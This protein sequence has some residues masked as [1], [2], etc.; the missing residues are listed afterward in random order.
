MKF[1]ILVK[2]TNYGRVDIEAKDI[3]AAKQK[4]EEE[5][6]AGK[7][8]WKDSNFEV[9]SARRVLERNDAR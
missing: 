7:I 4:A 1:S 5:Y 3:E 2:E 6:F 9:W 8:N